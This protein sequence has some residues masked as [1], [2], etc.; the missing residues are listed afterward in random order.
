MHKNDFPLN[1]WNGILLVCSVSDDHPV[2][3][4]QILKLFIWPILCAHTLTCPHSFKLFFLLTKENIIEYMLSSEPAYV[5]RTYVFLS[6]TLWKSGFCFSLQKSLLLWTIA[7]SNAKLNVGLFVFSFHWV[8]ITIEI[9]GDIDYLHCVFLFLG[10]T[11]KVIDRTKSMSDVYG[12]FYDFSLMLK[13]KVRADPT[14]MIFQNSVWPFLHL[15]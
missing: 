1:I 10:L 3:L 9:A 5:L 11:A 4:P 12:A 8:R 14:L 13:S 15:S 2:H 6:K 7:I